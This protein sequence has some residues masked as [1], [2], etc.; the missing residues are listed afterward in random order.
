MSSIIQ[1]KDRPVSNA[2]DLARKIRIIQIFKYYWIITVSLGLLIS[3]EIG[4]LAG[5][6]GFQEVIVAFAG[7]NSIA[8]QSFDE[9]F[10]K[11]FLMI[12]LGTSMALFICSLFW[13]PPGSQKIFSDYSSK[14]MLIALCAILCLAALAMPFYSYSLSGGGNTSGSLLVFIGA[15]SKL[16]ALTVLNALFGFAQLFFLTCMRLC[17]TTPVASND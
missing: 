9:A 10:V 7:V 12:S 13:V 11:G 6:G 3:N 5:R 17:L 2:T 15:S 8:S 1:I 16:G 14:V 4:T